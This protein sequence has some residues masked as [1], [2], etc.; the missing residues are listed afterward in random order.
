MHRYL[1]SSTYAAVRG[2][3]SLRRVMIRM[4][5]GALAALCFQTATFGEITL[6]EEL[7]TSP[8]PQWVLDTL[9]V[10]RVTYNDSGVELIYR[11]RVPNS[12]P[13]LYSYEPVRRELNLL[14]WTVYLV[15]PKGIPCL[16]I[17]AEK[18][19]VVNLGFLSPGVYTLQISS[20]GGG[21]VLLQVVVPAPLGR[22]WIRSIEVTDGKVV[23][24]AHLPSGFSL[25][26]LES[27]A[28]PGARW[29]PVL[30][31]RLDG[32][33][34]DVKLEYKEATGWP[35]AELFRLRTETIP[36]LPTPKN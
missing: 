5:Q 18:E 21:E 14:K 31:A 17:V 23:L 24:T 15:S 20:P 33:E 11:Y 9:T 36:E 28:P 4:L 10:D 1:G 25:L 22:P 30:E 19:G 12:C 16:P 2:I 6:S 32:S 27:C 35:L 29:R 7:E 13:V 26:V 34:K 3:H 8:C